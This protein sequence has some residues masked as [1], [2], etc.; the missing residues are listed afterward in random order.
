MLLGVGKDIGDAEKLL[1]AVAVGIGEDLVVGVKG[2][3]GLEHITVADIAEQLLYPIAEQGL[4]GGRV[5]VVRGIHPTK[6]LAKGCAPVEQADAGQEGEKRQKMHKQQ[7]R[8][9]VEHNFFCLGV[10]FHGFFSTL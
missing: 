7:N 5:L 1:G 3:V 9:F 4:K 6:P 10:R 2:A 8:L